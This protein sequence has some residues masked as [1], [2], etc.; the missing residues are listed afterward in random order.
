MGMFASLALLIVWTKLFV[1]L[2][3]ID[4]HQFFT[5]GSLIYGMVHT[6]FWILF[7]LIGTLLAILHNAS[8]EEGWLASGIEE[9]RTW[10]SQ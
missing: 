8:R 3:L 1:G 5:P 9:Y 2:A 6:N 4:L 10:K 7:Y